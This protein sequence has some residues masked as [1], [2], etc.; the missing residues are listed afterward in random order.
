MI[1]ISGAP[2]NHA[3]R[4]SGSFSKSDPPLGGTLSGRYRSS[5]Y[6]LGITV[7]PVRSS[8]QAS[9]LPQLDRGVSAR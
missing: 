1:L 4:N 6:V 8:S 9:Q 2:S 7:S 3:G 5:G